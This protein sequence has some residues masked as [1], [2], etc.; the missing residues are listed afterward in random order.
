MFMGWGEIL[1]N[2]F[3]KPDDYGLKLKTDA[4]SI[5][6]IALQIMSVTHFYDIQCRIRSVC[7]FALPG[8]AWPRRR[9][10][11]KMIC[12]LGTP[13]AIKRKQLE[14]IYSICLRIY[15]GYVSATVSG[16][17]PRTSWPTG[18]T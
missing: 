3:A 18:C 5:K 7:E 12:Q 2:R 9:R 11:V 16:H 1:G 6:F 17:L 4:H 15:V 13:S 14:C 10:G 8:L